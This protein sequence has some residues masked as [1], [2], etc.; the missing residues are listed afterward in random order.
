M[1]ISQK[2]IAP[3]FPNS[4]QKPRS[5]SCE[6]GNQVEFSQ[7]R[8]EPAEQV[9]KDQYRMKGIKEIVGDMQSEI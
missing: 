4:Q 9:E 1:P 7:S 3:S 6:Q 2:A 5:K 8:K